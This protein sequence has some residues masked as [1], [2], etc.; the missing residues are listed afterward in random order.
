MKTRTQLLLICLGAL[1]LRL[2][3]VNW[4]EHPG[5]ADPNHYYNLGRELAT[6]HGFQIDY[7]WHYYNPPD[8]VVHPIDWWMPLTGL[9][10]ASSMVV[11]GVSVPAAL[12]PF[13]LLG[14]LLPVVTFFAARQFACSPKA[15]LFAAA[16]AGVLPEFYLNS[17]RT[18]TVIP[19]TLLV[20][21]AVV[22]F[23]AWWQ[24]GDRRG[25]LASGGLVGLAYLTRSENTLLIPALALSAA[26][27]W[28]LGRAALHRAQWRAL[29]GALGLAGLVVL[30]WLL[31][32]LDVWG[33]ATF[34]DQQRLFFWTDIRHHFAYNYPLTFDTMLAEQGWR[35]AL[36]KRVFEMLASVKIMIT[37]LDILALV[38]IGGGLLVMARREWDRL[39]TLTPVL[40]A[41]GGMFVFYTALAPYLS[42]GG[43][44]KK[45]HL[46]LV[47]LLIPLGAYALE[48]AIPD[49][50][51]RHGAMVLI[52]ML[53]ALNAVEMMRA[54]IRFTNAYLDTMEDVVEQARALPDT[55]G[56]GE[57]VLMA[58]D[59]FMLSFLGVKS[60][61]IPM[62]DRATILEVAQ[63]Y[64]VDY[65]VM[66]PARPA[67]DPLYHGPATDPRFVPV[68][69]VDEHNMALYAFDFD[70]ER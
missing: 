52:V 23:T 1:A 31:R 61:Q 32:N 60:V 12:L 39:L 37:N 33:W 67:L 4:V 7:I 8:A 44:F 50:R 3:L 42:Q 63:R 26:L 34:P 36:G 20:S 21:A 68:A 69:Q 30:P 65:L 62:N 70:A 18:N 51:L 10:A 38:V 11:L 17:L 47:P 5:I 64:Q 43:S 56:D 54:D 35:G 48:Q 46:A 27:Y 40:L 55:N 24:R 14:V 59:Q 45:A 28:R 58:Q 49:A 29:L 16:A 19:N 2:A 66:P 13:I 15:S 41:L 53:L 57:L 6:G 9:I 22:C 25:L